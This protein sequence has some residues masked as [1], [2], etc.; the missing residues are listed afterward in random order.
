MS[1]LP[2]GL[3]LIED[4]APLWSMVQ[5]H[6]AQKC[7]PLF[8]LPL[9]VEC[10][11]AKP[12]SVSVMKTFLSGRQRFFIR[13]I[14]AA[15]S[16]AGGVGVATSVDVKDDGSSIFVGGVPMKIQPFATEDDQTAVLI[17]NFFPA[18]GGV[19]ADSILTIEV[20]AVPAAPPVGLTVILDI[21]MIEN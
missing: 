5:T 6:N 12:V 17:T 9:L 1:E 20:L 21:F 14:R 3:Q 8:R 10:G 7:D 15:V 11:Y 13:N 4:G 19:V 2:N 18:T 16:V